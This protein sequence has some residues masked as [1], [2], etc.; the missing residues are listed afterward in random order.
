MQQPDS[1][2]NRR[3]ETWLWVGWAL[4]LTKC[5]LSWWA[6]KHYQVPIHPLWLIIPTLMFAGLCTVLYL[7]RSRDS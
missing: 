4:I 1:T 6:M 7:G 5:V 2:R 3:S